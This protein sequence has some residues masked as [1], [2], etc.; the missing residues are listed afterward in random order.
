MAP[1]PFT[2]PDEPQQPPTGRYAVRFAQLAERGE[3]AFIPFTLLGWPNREM[4]RT[5][6]EAMIDSGATAL[7]LGIAFSDP[8][9]DGPLIQQAAAETLATGFRVKDAMALLKEIRLR[10]PE[11]PI[12]LLV[13]YNLVL[14]QEPEAFFQQLATVGVDGVLIPDLP[15]EAAGEIFPIAR[16][17]GIELIF[18]ISP[19]TSPARLALIQQY[20]GGFLYIVSRLG[21]TGVEERY[22]E[23]LST[24]LQRIRQQSPLPMCVGF[25]I[26]QPD[27]AR[28]MFQLGADGVIVGSKILQLAQQTAQT[29]GAEAVLPAL[30]GYLAEMM[31]CCTRTDPQPV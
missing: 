9:A 6:I 29:Q 28:K 21:I 18:I 13:Y 3:K 1:Q 2:P 16:R 24:L 8:V 30:N 4:S 5:M 10:A 14:R 22:D 26:S 7:E 15:P 23:T 17:H 20:A 11:L 25:G 19:L 12:G 31:A 27:H